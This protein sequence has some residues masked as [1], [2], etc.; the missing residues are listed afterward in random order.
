MIKCDIKWLEVVG[1]SLFHCS[2]VAGISRYPVLSQPLQWDT[3]EFNVKV[4][5]SKYTLPVEMKFFNCHHDHV[6]PID[7]SLT[8]SW[9]FVMIE[10]LSKLGALRLINEISKRKCWFWCF[11]FIYFSMLSII[12]TFDL[13]Q[14][15]GP[16]YLIEWVFCQLYCVLFQIKWVRR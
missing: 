4:T 9:I 8:D 3:V 11:N 6:N 16:F 13:F 7:D 5:L 12:F 10:L 15:L 2:S 14:K 1:K